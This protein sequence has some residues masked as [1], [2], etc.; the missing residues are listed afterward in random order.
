MK[1]LLVRLR[2]IGDVVLTTP[3]IA[4]LR[5][6]FPTAHLAYL[7]EP[8]AA[9][10]VRANPHLDDVIVAAPRRSSSLRR[11]RA[12]LA[13]ARR[14]RRE[15]FDIAIDLHGGPR[16][17]WLTLASGAAMRIGYTIPGRSWMY[18]HVV[19]RSPDLAPRHS[20]RTQSDLLAPLGI[21]DADPSTTPVEMPVNIAAAA[22]VDAR[23][24]AAGI[25]PEHPL[26][27]VHVSANNPFRR[28]PPESFVEVLVRLARQDPRRRLI[29]QSGPSD[30]GAATRIASEARNKL[31]PSADAVPDLGEFDLEEIRVLA[32]RAAVYIGGDSGLMHI[33]ATSSVPI[34]AIL[35]PTLAERCQ[36]WRPP[37]AFV[38]ML[39]A[40][41]LPCRPCRQRHCEPGDFRCLT[42]VTA[43]R[44]VDAAEKGMQQ[45]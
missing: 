4:A 3:V 10:V 24:A 8:D 15:H 26:V 32:E 23:L 5:R 16:S 40:G 43:D 7:V 22:R 29:V 44:V 21:T 27:L 25:G 17:A 39:D 14:L 11:L 37:G 41:P 30:S 42:G 12:D 18:T 31:G 35:G 2:L 1:I 20:V 13:L 28:W 33:A 45:A 34:V 9:P 38:D 19:P 6:H 36:P